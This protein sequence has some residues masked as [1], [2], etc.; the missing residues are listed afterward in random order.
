M[1]LPIT[2]WRSTP[3]GGFDAIT[4]ALVGAQVRGIELGT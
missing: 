2:G 1:V 4:L 3:T